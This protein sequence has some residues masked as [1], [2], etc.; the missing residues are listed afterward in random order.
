MQSAKKTLFY[1]G[2]A[3]AAQPLSVLARSA[4]DRRLRLD[5]ARLIIAM[6]MHLRCQLVD[7][8]PIREVERLRLAMQEAARQDQP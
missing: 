1:R 3:Q 4:T 8:I 6:P 5:L 7:L 2:S